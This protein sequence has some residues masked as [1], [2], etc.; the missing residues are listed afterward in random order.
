VLEAASYDIIRPEKTPPA[1]LAMGFRASM[2]M[3]MLCFTIALAL[4]PGTIAAAERPDSAFPPAGVSGAPRPPETGELKRVPGSTRT[5][6]RSQID[7]FNDPPDWF[8]D[9]HPPTPTIV[10]RGKGPQVRACV[11]CHLST[12]MGHP[13]NSRLAGAPS[14]Y[15]A[16]ACRLRERR[17]EGCSQHADV[18]PRDDCGRD[19]DCG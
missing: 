1:L 2:T 4:L 15:R 14:G 13:E 9:E 16:S 19:E 8:P 6:T 10:A 5:Y 18:C 17:A 12:G 3:R 11:S 7:S